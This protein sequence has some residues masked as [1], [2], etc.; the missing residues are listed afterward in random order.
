M[1]HASF[2]TCA[3][4][5]S[6]TTV[7]VEVNPEPGGWDYKQDEDYLHYDRSRCEQNLATDGYVDASLPPE[8]QAA[9]DDSVARVLD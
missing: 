4:S 7:S 3:T 2:T 6:S 9:I 1:T 8:Q 5:A